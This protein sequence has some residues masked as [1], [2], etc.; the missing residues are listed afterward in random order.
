MHLSANTLPA[1]VIK[2]VSKGRRNPQTTPKRG[3]RT[4]RLFYWRFERHRLAVA[5][6][7]LRLRRTES[8]APLSD[9]VGGER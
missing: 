2:W 9:E 6:G 8:V 1:F 5:P 4:L 3:V 7:V